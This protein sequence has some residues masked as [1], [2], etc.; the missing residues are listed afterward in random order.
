MRLPVDNL[1]K[2]TDHLHRNGT[3]YFI[4][5]ILFA[6][7]IRFHGL[8]HDLPFSYYGDEL[9]FVKR[10]VSL[11]NGDLNPHWF[12]KPAFLMY[13]LLFFYGLYFVA[14]L[15]FGLFDSVAAFGAHFLADMGPFI[16]IGRLVVTASGI[17]L[18]AASYVLAR[19]VLNSNVAALSS[20]L[21]I[22]A[23]F[24]LV[25]GS[26]VVKADVPS[27]LFSILALILYLRAYNST[28]LT[29]LV[30]SAVFA[31]LSMATKY[32]GV[33]VLPGIFLAEFSRLLRGD[34]TFSFFV[35]RSL[36]LGAAFIFTFFVASPFNFL[37]PTWGRD[38]LER[39][40]PYISG[41]SKVAYDPDSK[42]VFERGFGSF[43]G[44]FFFFFK[45]IANDTAYSLPL[46][47]LSLLGF[48]AVIR[49]PEYRWPALIVALPVIIFAVLAAIFFTYHINPR[50]LSALFPIFALFAFPGAY[51]ALSIVRVPGSALNLCSFLVVVL[52]IA[53]TALLSFENNLR[54]NRF[55][56]R[57][58]A[59]AW[60]NENIS[61]SARVLIDDYGPELNPG[62]EAINRLRERLDS[63]PQDEGFT[64]GQKR[65]F[66]LLLKYPPEHVFNID[67][68]GH[69]WWL[70]E[71]KSL[72]ELAE[73]WE[74][75]DM[76][77]PLIDRLPRTIDQYR[78]DGYD[79]II[80]N[81]DA[82]GRYFPDGIKKDTFPSFFRFY[83][84]LNDLAPL[85]TFD[86]GEWDGKGPIV[87]I[88]KLGPG[89][90][91]DKR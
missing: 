74:D 31:G 87:W 63:F 73:S 45:V 84:S 20:A 66:D 80:T 68:L 19:R 51:W 89:K 88:Y 75:R 86:P 15:L 43:F 44:G 50:Q 3:F 12:H 32:Y 48:F 67:R 26:Q 61:S 41:E 40:M 5:L 90:A 16:L 7:I 11:G 56:S 91:E 27:A 18:V 78:K 25:L 46:S 64:T 4:G 6:L 22:A 1:D 2:F 33:I 83:R 60:I 57:I 30:L 23:L 24:P 82:S 59:T 37:D 69:Q 34:Q 71:E 55:D 85:K 17:G 77:N 10:S 9:S 35:K 62:P 79:Y 76:G 36:I 39:I 54:I 81:S 21:I 42:I 13:T 38:I 49:N 47:I 65:R 70:P 29:P 14:G 8:F 28:S 53:P 72:R 52:A 58:V